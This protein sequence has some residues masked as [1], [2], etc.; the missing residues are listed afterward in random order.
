MSQA[1]E[2]RIAR[3]HDLSSLAMR[4]ATLPLLP[5]CEWEGEHAALDADLAHY[6]VDATQLPDTC[7]ARAERLWAMALSAALD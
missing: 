6:D 7:R 4:Y 1:T 5:E 3:A 2:D